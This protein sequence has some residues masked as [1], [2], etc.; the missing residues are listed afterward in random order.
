MRNDKD[1]FY[2]AP[3]F[4]WYIVEKGKGYVPTDKA[5]PEAVEAMRRVNERSEKGLELQISLKI[6]SVLFG[7]RIFYFKNN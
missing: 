6:K 4:D 3:H 1:F 5:P 2:F 7:G